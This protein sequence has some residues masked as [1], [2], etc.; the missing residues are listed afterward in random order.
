MITPASPAPAK[1]RV[2]KRKR[3]KR[4]SATTRW[5]VTALGHELRNLRTR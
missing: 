5:T 1:P 2:K 4:I 3:A